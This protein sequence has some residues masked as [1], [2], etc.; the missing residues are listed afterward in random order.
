MSLAPVNPGF[1]ADFGGLE[2]LKGAARAEDPAAL[3]AA[4]RQFESLFTRMLLKAMREASLA[5]G[6]GEGE[7]TR[8]YQ[9]MYDQQ[10][11]VVLSRGRGLGLADLLVEQLARAGLS[12]PTGAAGTSG[13]G[14]AA[15]AGEAPGASAPAT[16]PVARQTDFIRS[17]LPLAEAAGRRLGVAPETVIAHA[18]LES[19]WGRHVPAIDGQSS[20]NFF[21]IKAQRGWQGAALNASTT[22]FVGGAARRVAADF[23]SY[24][25]AAAG[26]ADYVGLL[27]GNARYAGA[28]NTGNDVAAFANALR[29]AGYATDPDYVRKLVSTAATVRDLQ[30]QHGLKS[31]SGVPTTS[32]AGSA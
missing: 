23:R 15:A 8:F 7:Q 4:A 32:G 11:S 20:F 16:A 10:L 5:E 30:A 21:G 12:R 22:E 13:T 28:L 17:M 26:V 18:A 9:D 19:G 25:S 3:R 6:M 2:R 27:A 24:R 14:G 29:R 31:T 1:Y